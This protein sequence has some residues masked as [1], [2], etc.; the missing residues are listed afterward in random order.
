M[1]KESPKNRLKKLISEL[2]LL[3]KY[4]LYFRVLFYLRVVKRKSS[5]LA[6]WSG[7]GTKTE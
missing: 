2:S 6:H 1:R 3:Q 7:G 4:V 5:R